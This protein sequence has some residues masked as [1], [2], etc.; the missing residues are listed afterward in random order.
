MLMIW[1]L[2][3]ARKIM[4]KRSLDLLAQPPTHQAVTEFTDS[5]ALK[6]LHNFCMSE[7]KYTQALE[8]Y[9]TLLNHREKYHDLINF[10]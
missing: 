4:N 8:K 3:P 6:R 2:L 7:K 9:K 10:L 1:D 5:K